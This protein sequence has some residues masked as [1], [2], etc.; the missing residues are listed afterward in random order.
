VPIIT[1]IA[2]LSTLT[3]RLGWWTQQE[4]YDEIAGHLTNDA[5]TGEIINELE[6]LTGKSYP[7]LRELLQKVVD[8]WRWFQRALPWNKERAAGDYDR[9]LREFAGAVEREASL[10]KV[11]ALPTFLDKVKGYL[12]Y[13]ALAG[14]VIFAGVLIS[15]TMK[16]RGD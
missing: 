1:T 13:I 5:S 15:K 16:K 4:W 11:A 8:E 2:T 6:R 14:G 7:Y 12:P 3:Q 10:I 9:A